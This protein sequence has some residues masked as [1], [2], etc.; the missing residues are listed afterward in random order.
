MGDSYRFTSVYCWRRD[1]EFNWVSIITLVIYAI[2]VTRVWATGRFA[3]KS[4][5]CLLKLF[6]SKV[7]L[8]QFRKYT[9]KA[10][11]VKMY[12]LIKFLVAMTYFK[13]RGL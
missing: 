11:L 10:V 9:K 7:F 13:L 6:R 8:H 1:A 4:F 12:M 2:V 3:T 5:R